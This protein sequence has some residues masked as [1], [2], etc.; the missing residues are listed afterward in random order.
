MPAAAGRG[1]TNR[2]LVAALAV[3]AVALAIRLIGIDYGLPFH[4][5]WDEPTIM[6]RVIRMGGGDLNPHF[7]FYPTLLMYVFLA[8]Q[9][10]LYGV[11][12]L[13]HIYPSGDAFLVSYLTDSTASY[14]VGRVI[15]AGAGAA[16]VFV[17]YAV[18]RRFLSPGVGLLAAAI[19]A[20]SPVHVANSH[21]AT[22][23]VPMGFF[24]TLTYIFLWQ[25]YRRGLR[26]DYVATGVVIGLATSTKYLPVVLL[27]CVAV[28]HVF[29]LHLSG[30]QF[31]LRRLVMSPMLSAAVA[32]GAF[33]VT[34][35]FVLLD[36]SNALNDYRVQ[37]QLSSAAGCT[38]CPFNFVPYL[39]NTLGWSVGWPVYLLALVG[40]LS[41]PFQ[42]GERRFRFILLASWPVLLFLMIGF[43]RQP[44]ARWLVP[45]A[46]FASLAAAAVC[47]SV[48]RRISAY[49]S[50]GVRIRG[51]WAGFAVL[52]LGL[53]FVQPAFTSARYDSVL[54]QKDPRTA[55]VD[56][57]TSNVATGTKIAV[58]PLLDRYFFTAQLRTSSQLAS[59]EGW[60]PG[61]RSSA[62]QEFEA[63]YNSRPV[64]EDVAFVYDY[65]QL[66]NSGVRYVVISSA[67][68]HEVDA[69]AE[70]RF[71]AQLR[72]RGRLVERFTALSP[73]PDADNFPV[74]PPAISVYELM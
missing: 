37:G 19:L 6:N 39:T 41:I 53:V 47:I 69:A 8:A 9:G 44:W 55:T 71:Y 27:V 32:F 2:W 65:D 56:W 3:T 73:L 12:H 21:F 29:R 67:H 26:R 74:S 45:I 46:P 15:V 35:P 51:A 66:K 11:G 16:T 70:D 64:Y 5:H 24:A 40:L 57:F 34:S 13:L 18:G 28:A 72:E 17:T 7:F 61:S 30:E 49:V 68:Y 14:V 33:A 62:R 42:F 54:L 43:Q 25:V 38:D 63:A 58:Q 48:Y 4:Y 1:R 23:D 22:N 31:T 50:G 52:G 60:I 36:W 10:V 59:E 20:I